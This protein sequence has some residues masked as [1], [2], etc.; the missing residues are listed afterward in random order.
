MTD[1]EPDTLG[2]LKSIKRH[3]D[4]KVIAPNIAWGEEY[5]SWSVEKRLHR[6]E[7]VAA[8]MNHAADVLQKERDAL[9]ETCKH[10]EAQLKNNTQQYTAQGELLHS[11]LG[12]E[13][14]EKQKLYEKILSLKAAIKS[15][16]QK[17][18]E[19]LRLKSLVERQAEE[20]RRLR[21]ETSLPE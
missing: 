20:I 7:R 4:M 5:N 11:R 19:V 17:D 6:A 16:V 18:E 10:Q 13:N 1:F 9:V 15:G 12:Q 8:A 14:A 2:E 3:R 21:A